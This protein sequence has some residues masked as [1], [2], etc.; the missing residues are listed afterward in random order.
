MS[1]LLLVGGHSQPDLSLLPTP[2]PSLPLRVGKNGR[3]ALQVMTV[4]ATISGTRPWEV[5]DT[6]WDSDPWVQILAPTCP[7]LV[8]WGSQRTPPDPHSCIQ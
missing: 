3:I 2:T 1:H 7:N 5:K 8:A 4:T 6:A